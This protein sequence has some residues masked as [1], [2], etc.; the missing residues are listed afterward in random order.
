MNGKIELVHFQLTKNCN[1]RCWFCGQWGKKGF[2][3]DASGHEMTF[4]DW[5]NVVAQLCEYRKE[6][7][8]TPHI[9]LWGGEPLVYDHFKEIVRLLRNND[10]PLGLVTNG[11][12]IDKYAE[13][14]KKEFR[15]IYVSI[16]GDKD[17][18]DSI[19]GKGV[20]EKTTKNLDLLRGT[21]ATISIMTVLTEENLSALETTVNALLNLPCDEV[22]LQDMI[23][24][25]KAEIEGYKQ[26][27]NS[28]GVEANYIDSWYMQSP[29]RY[30]KEKITEFCKRYGG[31]LKYLPHQITGVCQSAWKHVHIAW[32]GNVL[33]C[34]DFY[35]FS[36]GNVKE[37]RLLDIFR[38]EKTTKYRKLI[39]QN[40]C[41]T[42]NH[43][44]WRLSETFYL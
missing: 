19:R 15:H 37:E 25:T 39:E 11:T 24:L 35:D 23:A 1:L 7:G 33:Y 27:M 36:A 44:S 6:S 3:A 30:D 31:R 26:G 9:M 38:N 5:E 12:N 8:S 42:C 2:F 43:C 4:S 22:I 18:H 34:T 32:N 13:I 14:L 21:K 20:F 17:I 10:F 41:P 16:D 40:G 28:I 29:P